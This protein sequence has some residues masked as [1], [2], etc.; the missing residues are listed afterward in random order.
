MKTYRFQAGAGALIDHI[1]NIHLLSQ[2]MCHQAAELAQRG[3]QETELGNIDAVLVEPGPH[4]STIT[5]KLESVDH[6]E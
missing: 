3:R 4:D 1:Q 6:G 5:I 2:Q